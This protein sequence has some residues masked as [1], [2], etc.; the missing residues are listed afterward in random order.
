MTPSYSFEDLARFIDELRSKGFRIGIDQYFDAREL[1][2]SRVA[3]ER[4]AR[5][6]Q[7]LM[8]WLA[9]ILCNTAEEQEEFYL[10]YLRWL[11]RRAGNLDERTPVVRRDR[12]WRRFYREKRYRWWGVGALLVAAIVGSVF[13]LVE[14]K[15]D[16]AL[17]PGPDVVVSNASSYK[18]GLKSSSLLHDG[19][20]RE[21]VDLSNVEQMPQ[22]QSRMIEVPRTTRLT[23]LVVENADRLP[24]TA[25]VELLSPAKYTQS[26]SEHGFH[27]LLNGFYTRNYN[28]IRGSVIALPLVAFALWWLWSAYRQRQLERRLTS[29]IPRSKEVVLKGDTGDPF[30]DPE[31]RRAVPALR[32]HRASNLLELDIA[33]TVDATTRNGGWF[34]PVYSPRRVIP[35]YL[36]LID[37]AGFS[38]QQARFFEE[39]VD[40]LVESGI[41]ADRYYITGNP[42]VCYRPDPFASPLSLSDLAAMHPDHQL[43]IF[44]DGEGMFNPLNGEP[45]GW[46]DLFSTWEPRVLLTPEAV[47]HPKSR[48]GALQNAGFVLLPASTPGISALAEMLGADGTSV[49]LPLGVPRPYPAML[50]EN[51]EWWLSKVP[52]AGAVIADLRLQ[53][54]NYLGI[55]GYHLLAACALFPMLQWEMTLFFA[56]DLIVTEDSEEML[57]ALVRLPW[58]RHGSI[59]E[60]LRISL[61]ASLPKE[62]EKQLR[63]MVDDLLSGKQATGRD[64]E[65]SVSPEAPR[66][67]SS[68]DCLMYDYVF[69]SFLVGRKPRRLAIA[70]PDIV[71][72]IFYRSDLFRFSLRPAPFLALA[73]ASVLAAIISFP[74]LPIVPIPSITAAPASGVPGGRYA[75]HIAARDLPNLHLDH[76]RLVALGGDA[77]TLTNPGTSPSEMIATLSVPIEHEEGTIMLGI[78]DG[79]ELIG[80]IPFTV[81]HDTRSD[82]GMAI[83]SLGVPLAFSPFHATVGEEFTLDVTSL[84]CGKIDLRDVRL[85]PLDEE[86]AAVRHQFSDA[87]SLH[88]MVY[89]G[90]S[91]RPGKLRLA[92]RRGDENVALLT[93]RI[94]DPYASA[95]TISPTTI[96]SGTE[97]NVLIT[98][99]DCRRQSLL[100]VGSKGSSEQRITFSELTGWAMGSDS[101]ISVARISVAPGISPGTY[102]LY[103]GNGD[104]SKQWALDITVTPPVEE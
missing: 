60:W 100:T 88:A 87:C 39:M 4:L 20:W 66:T 2:A 28:A 56:K 74:S 84:D 97:K 24:D 92:A 36:V 43:L 19:S 17:S 68:R 47:E 35:E 80:T 23:S 81:R 26:A 34:S 86:R 93:I 29:A 40:R 58:F 63:R 16:T 46:L 37:R 61:V 69:V 75:L 6:P 3:Q 103:L 57:A 42:R 8:T 38:D 52:P 85:V 83:S 41:Y 50:C 15:S 102:Q 27:D 79:E 101:C 48:R 76:T 5:S 53:L 91:A 30:D 96:A 32:R 73:A 71:R 98:C 7:Q 90:S 14:E 11:E 18:S 59:P 72:R 104:G 77:S 70:L 22:Q 67:A 51:G 12:S 55:E 54:L 89:V 44:S 65:L 31:L 78:R 45:H 9:P 99:N 10:E 21:K 62:R 95:F 49:A 1:L 82:N 25:K 33:G 64:I 94:D 13:V